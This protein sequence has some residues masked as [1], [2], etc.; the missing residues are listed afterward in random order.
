V[1]ETMVAPVPVVE[2]EVGHG[3]TADVIEGRYG[4]EARLHYQGEIAEHVRMHGAKQRAL[5]LAEAV[6]ECQAWAA[7]ER[8]CR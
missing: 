1:A 3:M 5:T 8:R 7:H 2:V 4:F 6:D